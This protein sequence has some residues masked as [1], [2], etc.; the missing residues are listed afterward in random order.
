MRVLLT[1]DDSIHSAAL[2][3][4]AQAF[5]RHG[6]EVFITAP[7]T[8]QSGV[9][10]ACG[11][12]RTP[13]VAPFQGLNCEAWMISGTPLDCVNI[14]L[15]YLIHDRQPDLVVS[16]INW[17]VNV[18]VPVVFSSGT[19]G[20]ALEG[21]AWGTPS[22]AV[23]QSLPDQDGQFLQKKFDFL[24]HAGLMKSIVIAAERTLV[25]AEEA[26]KSK[27]CVVHNINFPYPLTEQTEVEHTRLSDI[28]R[29][30]ACPIYGPL[31]QQPD[32][33]GVCRFQMPS[34]PEIPFEPGTDMAALLKGKISHSVLDLRRLCADF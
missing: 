1:N 13:E 18:S 9:G 22:I 21:V 15:S 19:V 28:M 23:S 12:S 29:G 10:R 20:G 4:L 11:L 3:H 7:A 8:E 2:H 14:A 25:F 27:E 16:G 24:S 34:H 26:V 32:D 5:Q 30:S 31:Y 33:Q 17:G 6:W